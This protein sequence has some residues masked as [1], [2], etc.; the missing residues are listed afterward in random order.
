MNQVQTPFLV[1]NTVLFV[2]RTVD[3]S[4]NANEGVII[5]G[6][7]TSLYL[8]ALLAW[9]FTSSTAQNVRNQRAEGVVSFTSRL[10]ALASDAF[11]MAALLWVFGASILV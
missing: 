11:V 7:L 1:F 3:S 6:A 9:Q 5:S 4:A 8:A 10:K 2:V